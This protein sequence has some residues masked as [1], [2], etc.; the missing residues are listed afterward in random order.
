MPT[1]CGAE[2]GG[3][4]RTRP[5]RRTVPLQLQA[6][7]Q[8][9]LKVVNAPTEMLMGRLLIGNGANATTPGAAGAPGGLL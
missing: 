4:V 2:W 7:E 6:V 1:W 5:S 3:G 9:A 8:A